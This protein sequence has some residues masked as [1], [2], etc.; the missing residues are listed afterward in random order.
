MGVLPVATRDMKS[1][2]RVADEGAPELLGEL[3]IEGR[4]AER[5]RVGR[6]VDLVMKKRP[7]RHVERDVDERFV[8]RNRHGGEAT[9][10]GLRTERFG[11]RFTKRDASVFDRVMRVDFEIALC[12]DRQVDAAV[13]C[14][15]ADHVVKKWHA[16]RNVDSTVTVQ[17]D[18]DRDIA[19]AGRAPTL[20][21]ARRVL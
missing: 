13:L 21:T 15:L 10:A 7:S 9:D 16:R 3:W 11:Y 14:E 17:V 8:E 20:G 5:G 4:R 19:L 18:E 12:R 2:R 6:E 1:H